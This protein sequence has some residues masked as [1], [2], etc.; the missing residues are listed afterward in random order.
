MDNLPCTQVKSKLLRSSSYEPYTNRQQ[1]LT[2]PGEVLHWGTSLPISVLLKAE[3]GGGLVIMHS[4]TSTFG[5]VSC[6]RYVQGGRCPTFQTAAVVA[7]SRP[8]GTSP[9]P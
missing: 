9:P 6:L 7:S 8:F 5:G 3:T 1:F 2:L 4:S